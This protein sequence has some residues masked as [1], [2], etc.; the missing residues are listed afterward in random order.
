MSVTSVIL[1]LGSNLDPLFHLRKALL[2][3]RNQPELVIKK[4]SRIYESE[5][6]TINNS[7]QPSYLNACLLLEVKNFDPTVFLAQIKQIEK[8]IG[9][10]KREK[11]HS[12]E[13]DLDILYVIQENHP[14][15][16]KNEYIQIPHNEF[17]NR[18]FTFF[19]AKEVFL[20]LN[21]INHLKMNE[22]CKVSNKYFWPQFSGIL[23]I[24][25][26]SF[27]D[28]GLFNSEEN[29][30]K[31]IHMLMNA[32]S[33]FIDIGAESTRPG[34]EIISINTELAR[35]KSAL[36][37][38][39]DFDIKV[40]ID[41]RNY[42]T[43]KFCLENFKVDMINDVS[44]FSDQRIFQLIKDYKV[45]AVCM[46]SLSIPANPMKNLNDN[47]NPIDELNNWWSEKTK[48]FIK[49]NLDLENIYF[50]PG[51]GFGKTAEQSHF[52]LKNLNQL[53]LVLSPV[54]LGY[55]RKSFYNYFETNPANKKDFET[56][57]TTAQINLAYAQVIRVHDVHLQKRALRMC[58]EF[59]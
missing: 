21:N 11:W 35:L 46:H 1:G 51:I 31:Q 44:G 47:L 9:R 40:S 12:R 13:I 56:A 25:P 58:H 26:D 53:N 50:D 5:A 3:I 48:I 55:S 37:L 59:Y 8:K 6:L 30:F 17:F 43:V 2:E 10:Q 54:Y 52:I 39:K 34:A 18:A 45:K 15:F 23:N 7:T 42:E 28:G 24:T 49:N 14:I 4:I 20:D 16:F 27:S 38:I 36:N 22:S 41:S 29:M 33:D 32:G 19:P 57:M